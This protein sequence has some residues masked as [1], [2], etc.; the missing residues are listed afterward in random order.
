MSTE[1]TMAAFFERKYGITEEDFN[2][3]GISL[4]FV[5]NYEDNAEQIKLRYTDDEIKAIQ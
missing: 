5:V 2:N 1:T 3:E 4:Q